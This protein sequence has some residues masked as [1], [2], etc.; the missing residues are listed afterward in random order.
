MGENKTMLAV[1]RKIELIQVKKIDKVRVKT[2]LIQPRKLKRWVVQEKAVVM[3][4]KWYN[5]LLKTKTMLLILLKT[6][7]MLLILVKTK[8]MLVLRKIELKLWHV[9]EKYVVMK[10]KT[11]RIHQRS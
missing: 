1:L 2:S 11:S 8:T 7:T 6:K 3:K 4:V 10:M 9:Q 5:I